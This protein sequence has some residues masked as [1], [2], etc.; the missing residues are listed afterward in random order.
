MGTL[1]YG[2]HGEPIEIPERLLTHLKMVMTAK[3]RRKERFTFSWVSRDGAGGGSRGTLWCDPSIPMRFVFDSPEAEALD[4]NLL[5]ELADAANSVRGLVVELEPAVAEP[6]HQVEPV[7]PVAEPVA[8][9]VA[10]AAAAGPG[11]LVAVA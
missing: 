5:R 3:L 7:Q 9:P 10:P 1:Y 2:N 11:T 4:P 8:E 6:L